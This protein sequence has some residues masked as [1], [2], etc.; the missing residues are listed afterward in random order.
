[1]FYLKINI[2]SVYYVKILKEGEVHSEF[3]INEAVVH[4]KMNDG[5]NVLYSFISLIQ[6]ST[7]YQI[8]KCR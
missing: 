8:N 4:Y 2:G 5:F 6:H 3:Y 7:E 1:M